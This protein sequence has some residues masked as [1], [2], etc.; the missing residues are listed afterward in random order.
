MISYFG[1]GTILAAS[2]QLLALASAVRAEG[3]V[4][5]S[6]LSFFLSFF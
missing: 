2:Y 1:L 3:I 4:L 5:V 6:L